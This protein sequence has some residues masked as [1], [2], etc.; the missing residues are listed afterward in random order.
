MITYLNQE[1]FLG[2]VQNESVVLVDF[3]ADWCGPCK[4]IH[5]VLEELS[6]ELDGKAVIAKVNVDEE[7]ALAATFKIRSIPTMI[8]FKDGEP[9]DIVVGLQPKPELWKRLTNLL[10]EETVA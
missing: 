5:P 4:A 3:Y 10:P 2:T 1:N 7:P 6:N 9:V 8:L